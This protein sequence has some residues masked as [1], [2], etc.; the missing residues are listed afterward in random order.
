MNEL[1]K[2]LSVSM[3]QSVKLNKMLDRLMDI[4]T[5]SKT[6]WF[7]VCMLNLAPFIFSLSD[8]PNGYQDSFYGSTVTYAKTQEDNSFMSDFEPIH[9]IDFLYDIYIKCEMETMLFMEDCY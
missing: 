4:N 2:G 6:H 8:Q 7:E 1:S 5:F 9:P 3:D